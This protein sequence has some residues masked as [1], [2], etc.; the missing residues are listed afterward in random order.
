MTPEPIA[1]PPEPDAPVGI[2]G[3]LILPLLHLIASPA[4][5]VYELVQGWNEGLAEAGADVEV[6][7]EDV[8]AGL[9]YLN[10]G[11]R[12]A[13]G[14]ALCA[15]VIV[16]YAAFCLIQFLRKKRQVPNLMIAFYLLL[17]ALVV[18]NYVLLANFPALW[19]A[20]EDLSDA[21]TGLI[22]TAIAMAIWIPYFIVSERVKNTFVR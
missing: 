18:G 1:A 4:R 7:V 2:G 10:T 5:I 22:R 21:R 11:E 16:L 14:F 19:T 8:I 9:E 12:I 17:G 13:A 3:W 15:A 20:P 6:G